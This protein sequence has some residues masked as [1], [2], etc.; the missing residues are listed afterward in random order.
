VKQIKVFEVLGSTLNTREATNELFKNVDFNTTSCIQLD[1]D[2]VEF[3]SRSFADE[4]YKR[5]A[6][7]ESNNEI[8]ISLVNMTDDV[9]KMLKAVTYTNQ[10][11]T[12]RSGKFNHIKFSS[13]EELSKYLLSH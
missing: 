7:I 10:N 13:Q 4:F 5:R 6:F 11:S 12:P 1:F 8:T 3:M 2:K 9:S